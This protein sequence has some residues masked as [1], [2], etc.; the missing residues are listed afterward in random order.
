MRNTYVL[1]LVITL[2]FAGVYWYQSAA[3]ECPV[4]LSYRLGSIDPA[5]GLTSDA[6][7]DYVRQAEMVWEDQAGRELF[8]YD[9]AADFTIDF[10]F[11]E[12]QAEANTEE[13][14]RVQLDE[15]RAE[16]EKILETV[17]SLQRDHEALS[18]AYS[19]KKALY[20]E[21]LD[22]YNTEV[23]RYNDRGGAPPEVYDRLNQERA[24]LDVELAEL[25]DTAAKLNQLAAQIN[26]LSE[27]GNE[28]VRTYN[29]GVNQYN[30]EFGFAR[31][32]TQG[33]YQGDRIHV[34]KFSSDTE[35]VTVLAH[36]FGHALGIDHVEGTSSLMYY[37]LEDTGT[38]PVLSADDLTAYQGVC[39]V[40]ETT[41]QKV[42]R[43]IREALAK[44]K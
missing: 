4:P 1:A 22:A 18:Q 17:Q 10:I 27:R 33:D 7:L 26:E 12:R 40:T 25:T 43:V 13:D 16:N 19:K 44:F 35:V 21:R 31:E 37:L 8:Q 38:V 39:G 2:F 15:Q 3:N 6:A 32:F 41:G 23:N 9:A 29:Q 42:R 14:L 20:E 30:T 36:E 24:A 5:F 28:L 11:D 34:Y